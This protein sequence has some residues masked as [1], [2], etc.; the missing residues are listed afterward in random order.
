MTYEEAK[1]ISKKLNEID[2][3]NKIVGLFDTCKMSLRYNNG[4]IAYT[5]DQSVSDVVKEM[6]REK[7]NRI[8]DELK[9]M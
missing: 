9:A 4:G 2:E 3:C 7:A 6:F 8:I 1:E 5:F